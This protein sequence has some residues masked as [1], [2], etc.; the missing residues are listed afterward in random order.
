MVVWVSGVSLRDSPRCRFAN[1]MF[2]RCVAAHRIN[3]FD[4]LT[5]SI[6]PSR[7]RT[8]ALEFQGFGEPQV[9]SNLAR[10]L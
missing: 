4:L 6:P 8:S 9:S 7:R 10:I 1:L 5:P 2:Y 3:A